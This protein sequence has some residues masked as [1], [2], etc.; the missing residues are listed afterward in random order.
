MLF[1]WYL[2]PI[3]TFFLHQQLKQ[4]PP[5]QARLSIRECSSQPSTLPTHR[6]DSP[7]AYPLTV[8]PFFSLLL[9]Q[10]C[11]VTSISQVLKFCLYKKLLFL[12]IMMS[13][14]L[15]LTQKHRTFLTCWLC[16]YHWGSKNEWLNFCLKEVLI[17][18]MNNMCTYVQVTM[19]HKT[20]QQM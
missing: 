9:L 18:E 8:F 20:M 10:P 7:T 6:Q 5:M 16:D 3:H 13:S 11:K 15:S 4:C 17:K 2:G 19:Q 14:Q 12:V 1:F